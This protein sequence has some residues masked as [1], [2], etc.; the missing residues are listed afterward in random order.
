MARKSNK[1]L[2]EELRSAAYVWLGNTNMDNTYVL[3]ANFNKQTHQ[4]VVEI[5]DENIILKASK[6][7]NAL[8][9]EIF[10]ILYEINPSWKKK[11]TGKI[12]TPAL[13]KGLAITSDW[14]QTF[15]DKGI[16]PL[17]ET[18]VIPFLDSLGVNMT[19]YEYTK[20]SVDNSHGLVAQPI[21]RGYDNYP[22][23]VLKYMV[24]TS[25][26]ANYTL[27]KEDEYDMLD[28]GCYRGII[29]A[30]PPATGKTTDAYT[31]AYR[32]QA[33]VI[34]YQCVH[35]TEAD[36]I[37]GKYVPKADGS[38][39]EFL[40]GPLALAVKYD[41]IFTGQEW[42]YAP[43]SVQ[44]I[45]NSLMDGNG[46]ITLPNG[47]V[48]T[49]GPNF[50][51]I[52]TVNPGYRGT[53]MFNAATVNRF[54]VVYY[55]PLDKKAIMER[56]K[57]ESKYNNIKVL[58]AIAEQFNKIHDIYV[59]KNFELDATYRNASRFLEMLLK[60]SNKPIEKQF[61]L[62][63]IEFM[64]LEVDPAAVADLKAIGKELLKD[65]KSAKAEGTEE[66]TESSWICS[67]QVD[68]EDL[69][70]QIGDDG[71]FLDVEEEA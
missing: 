35:N 65:I 70:S 50:R 36:D 22:K 12:N 39:F 64:H 41:C 63:F 3:L 30:G 19:M 44:S 53:N 21:V 56:L 7:T 6:E 46:R 16:K 20:L 27:T 26:Y 24:D 54:V 10:T 28:I 32:V 9:Q 67:P 45:V 11:E 33:P 66:V 13:P 61:N 34:D 59:S 37:I 40:Y 60:A 57:F 15:Y 18:T 31:W 25:K 71:S 58:D 29:A 68:I 43:S 69:T 1:S 4:I 52:L 23:E 8:S 49:V 47:E 5:T 2:A 62:A 51:M 14:N 55:E 48:L 17:K 38:G 42:N